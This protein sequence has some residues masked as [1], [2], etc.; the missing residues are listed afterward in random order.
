MDKGKTESHFK[1]KQDKISRVKEVRKR[2]TCK[3]VVK[4]SR[5][6]CNLKSEINST[7]VTIEVVHLLLVS[8]SILFPLLSS[9]TTP[10]IKPSSRSLLCM[11]DTP[12]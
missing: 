5:V 8:P 3:S 2:F 7:I 4:V 6:K 1:I 11:F 10:E 12:R 9:K